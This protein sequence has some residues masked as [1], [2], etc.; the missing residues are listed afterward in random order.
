MTDQ[1]TT[2][3]SE[4]PNAG[5]ATPFMDLIAAGVLA[6]I[7]AWFM[8]DSLLLPLPGGITTAPGLLPFLTAATLMIMAVML[9]IDAVKRRRNGI[10]GVPVPD[11]LE[12]PADFRRSMAL[13]AIFVGY[14]FALEYASIEVVF[15]AFTL[16]FLIGAF[17]VVTLIFLAAI[18]RIY[19]QEALWKCVAVS[20]GWIAFLSIVFR[21]V[22]RVPLP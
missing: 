11:G 18:L 14:V 6:A 4:D 19:W 7:A 21:L 5:H 17:E 12:L 22:Y 9:G 16:R 20:F 10:A 8:I 15:Q 2:A 1:P 13:G 3:L